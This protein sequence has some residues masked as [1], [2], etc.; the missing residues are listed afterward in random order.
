MPLLGSGPYVFGYRKRIPPLPTTYTHSGE[1]CGP[2]GVKAM[3]QKKNDRLGNR[4][5]TIG[6]KGRI[7]MRLSINELTPLVIERAIAEIERHPD[8]SAAQKKRGTKALQKALR[9]ACERQSKEGMPS[10]VS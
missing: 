3:G 10:V 7:A 1:R 2:D 5:S 8:L 9:R 6:R 4:P